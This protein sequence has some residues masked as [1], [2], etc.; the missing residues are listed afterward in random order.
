MKRKKISILGTRGIPAHHGGFESFAEHLSLYLTKKGWEVTVYC[1]HECANGTIFESE[2]RGIRLI[3]IPISWSNAKGT[4]LFDWKSTI[5][6]ASEKNIILTLG[7]NTAIFCILYR[8]K[9]IINIINM[10]GIEW[11][12]GKWTTIERSWLYLNE[13]IGAWLGNHLIADHPE[14]KRHLC[15]LVSST[16]I[17]TIPYRADIIVEADENILSQFKLK[18]NKYILLVARPEPENSILEI[19]R[20][21][22]QKTRDIPLVILGRYIPEMVRYHKKVLEAANEDVIFLGAIYDR[23]ILDPLRFFARFYIHGHTVGGTNPSLV[24]ALGAGNAVLAHHNKFN[25][26]V[27]GDNALFFNSE[28]ECASQ[29]ERLIID[30]SLIS[31]LSNSSRNQMA[32]HFTD[33]KTFN[34]YENLLDN[35]V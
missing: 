16:K 31:S 24:E 1:H 19:V 14:I 9:K 8:L 26:W 10:D 2:W 33:E 12:R 30:D 4:I 28:E 7:Y 20:A 17:T 23:T 11:Q 25:R 15:K 35:W 27:A 6:A 22:S 29:I 34:A 18:P 5:H 13:K 3:N 32:N 21:Y